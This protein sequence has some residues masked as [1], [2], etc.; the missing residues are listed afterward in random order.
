MRSESVVTSS[1]T[2]LCIADNL[3]GEG[4]GARLW[5]TEARVTKQMQLSVAFREIRLGIDE[6]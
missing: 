2:L 6:R 3:A 1:Y 5:D 4:A